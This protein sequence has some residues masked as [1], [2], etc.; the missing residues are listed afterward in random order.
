[1]ASSTPQ[2]NHV[3]VIIRL[4]M[5]EIVNGLA[6]NMFYHYG[7]TDD[8]F[9]IVG[10][11]EPNNETLIANAIRHCMHLV[12]FVSSLTIAYTWQR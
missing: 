9:L 7:E 5:S 1:M 12:D 2:P 4:K 8:A 3:Y 6:D 10:M 11:V